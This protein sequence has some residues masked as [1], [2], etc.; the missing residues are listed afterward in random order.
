M[1]DKFVLSAHTHQDT[2]LTDEL[3]EERI[4]EVNRKLE[5]GVFN[6]TRRNRTKT[7][8]FDTRSFELLTKSR[9][10][11]FSTDS[12]MKLKKAEI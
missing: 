3:R 8:Q 9:K 4:K 10:N 12:K 5:S 11:L 6:S 1:R 7:D 2:T